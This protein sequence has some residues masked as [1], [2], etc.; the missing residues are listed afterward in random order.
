MRYRFVSTA[1]LCLFAGLTFSAT[2]AAHAQQEAGQVHSPS[3]Y[4]YLGNVE[5]KP[6]QS[7]AYAKLEGEEVEA[8]RAANAPSHYV[9]MW[10]ITGSTKVLYMHGFNSFADLQKGHDDTVAMSKLQDTLKADDAEESALI[11]ERH[12]SIYS[13]EKDLSL[14]DPI[15]LSKMR[16]MRIILFHVRSGHDQDWEH[17]VKLFVKAYGSSIPEARWAMFQKMY[18]VGSDN[19][20]ILVTPMESL[21]TVDDMHDGSKKFADAVGED[22]LHAL[23]SGLDATVESSES[24]LFAFAAK[25]SYVPDS[26]ISSSA[27]FWGKK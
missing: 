25:I 3:K 10:S 8:L 15:D 16:F 14:G 11:S 23:R 24:D 4:L 17:V 27:E 12:S 26:W 20:Y 1:A 13:Y 9:A 21:S 19:T 5:L 22:Q 7:A 2:R 18:G 6:D